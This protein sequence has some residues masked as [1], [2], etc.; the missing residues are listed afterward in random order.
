MEEVDELEFYLYI[1]HFFNKEL[2][3]EH[4]EQQYKEDWMQ[5]LP[6]AYGRIEL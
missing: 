6:V 1:D 2:D 5:M 4:M 3:A